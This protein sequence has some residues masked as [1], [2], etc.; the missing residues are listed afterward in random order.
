MNKYV[1]P[2]VE[3]VEFEL[4]KVT[5]MDVDYGHGGSDIIIPGA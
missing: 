4:E 3:I 5:N 1:K 2:E